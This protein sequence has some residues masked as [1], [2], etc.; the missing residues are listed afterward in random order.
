MLST[1]DDS[2]SFDTDSDSCTYHGTDSGADRTPK[3]G[4]DASADYGAQASEG[5]ISAGHRQRSGSTVARGIRA[6]KGIDDA[7]N[8]QRGWTSALVKDQL[9]VVLADPLD[10][11][12]CV[13]R[14]EESVDDAC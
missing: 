13:R 5:G 14:V 2:T 9:A 8:R 4:A 11:V 10:S 6:D 1:G 12:S 3:A 7:R